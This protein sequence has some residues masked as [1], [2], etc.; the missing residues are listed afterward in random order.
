MVRDSNPAS[1]RSSPR[2]GAPRLAVLT[3][4]EPVISAL[5]GRRALQLLCRTKKLDGQ[6]SRRLT[7]DFV[8][9]ES[10]RLTQTHPRDLTGIRTRATSLR[11]W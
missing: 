7:Q 5:T 4:L 11:G 2:S 1:R 10:P 6:A 3:G 8:Y 9:E